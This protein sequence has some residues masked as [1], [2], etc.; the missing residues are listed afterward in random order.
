MKIKAIHYELNNEDFIRLETDDCNDY[1]SVHPNYTGVFEDDEDVKVWITNGKLHSI[2]DQPA[3]TQYGEVQRWYKHGKRHRETGYAIISSI[4]YAY[5]YLDGE[6][7][8]TV[9]ALQHAVL[10]R[11]MKRI[12]ST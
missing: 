7:Y 5:Y 12:V 4:G 3:M 8:Q 1:L 10:N 11:R 2:N 6:E 9:E